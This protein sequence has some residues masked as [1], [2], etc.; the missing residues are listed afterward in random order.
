MG[1]YYV[2][3]ALILVACALMVIVVLVQ[4]S[5]GGGLA[6]NLQNQNQYMGVRKTADFLEKS[7][8]TLAIG[9]CIL[10]LVSVLVIPKHTDMFDTTDTELRQNIE[11]TTPAQPTSSPVDYELPPTE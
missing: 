6:S 8:W 3:L 1:L 2:I 9:L 5:K 11:A 4:N 7:T 10:S